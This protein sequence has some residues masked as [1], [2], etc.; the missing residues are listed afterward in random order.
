MASQTMIFDLASIPVVDNHAH[1]LKRL[2]L[3]LNKE[4][5][6]SHFTESCDQ[7]LIVDHLPSSLYFKRSIA[8]ICNFLGCP[9]DLYSLLSRRSE[10]EEGPY[11]KSLLQD[12][13]IVALLLDVGFPRGAM[14]LDELKALFPCTVAPIL[15]IESLAEDLI[16][17]PCSFEVFIE[18]ITRSLSD[19][20]VRGVAA[21]KSIIA[22]R[23]GLEIGPADKGAATRDY[24]AYSK[25]ALRTGRRRILG[26][27][28]LNYLLFIALDEATRQSVPVQIHTG[29][30]DSDL[31]LLRSNPLLLRPLFAE[32][33]FSELDIVLLHAGY[34]YIREA[35]YLASIYPNAYVDISLAIPMAGHA[36][37]DVLRQL[38]E[39]APASKLLY[40]SD[41]HGIAELYWL[42]AKIGKAA[43]ASAL[44]Q[45]AESGFI[46]GDEAL[47]VA[48]MIFYENALKLYRLR[49]PV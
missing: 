35:G 8:E 4:E 39:L 12:A 1:P 37:P 29:F 22:Y 18:K 6:A 40:G 28:L 34:P 45:I 3:R 23:S 49:P 10:L 44:S 30:G 9:N 24:A 33:R 41:G 26:A 31:N 5:F 19:L 20:K 7:R 42:G 46:G 48:K 47:K 27:G 36:G 15:R 13:G 38:L 11:F 32:E 21:L 2:S 17:P 25:E 43:A 14:S 16:L